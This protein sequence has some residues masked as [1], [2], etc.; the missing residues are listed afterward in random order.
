MVEFLICYL[1]FGTL[2]TIFY[3]A[4]NPDMS[5]FEMILTVLASPVIL[6]VISVRE[7]AEKE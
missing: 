7:I 2:L 6:L 5:L 4:H 3:F 1:V